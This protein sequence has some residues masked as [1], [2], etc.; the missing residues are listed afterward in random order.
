LV[1]VMVLLLLLL[2][3]LLLR[4]SLLLV[5]LVRDYLFPVI[6]NVQLTSLGWGFLFFGWLVDYIFLFFPQYQL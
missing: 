5:L 1:V 4:A 2:L 3:L 6:S